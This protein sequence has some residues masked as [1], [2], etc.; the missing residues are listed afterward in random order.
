MSKHVELQ[1]SSA[2]ECVDA[3]DAEVHARPGAAATRVVWLP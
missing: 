2:P 3:M 1:A